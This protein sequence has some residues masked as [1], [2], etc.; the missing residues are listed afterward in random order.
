MQLGFGEPTR[1]RCRFAS[2]KEVK[3][4]ETIPKEDW[5]QT[6]SSVKSLV[7]QLVS[8]LKVVIPDES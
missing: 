7:K 8:T 2:R 4:K 5:E 3:M 6:P 1:M